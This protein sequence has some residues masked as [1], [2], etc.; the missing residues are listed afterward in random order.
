MGAGPAQTEARR[1]RAAP[2]WAWEFY[3][4]VFLRR[5]AALATEEGGS[6]EALAA[7]A[8]ADMVN[9]AFDDG[10]ERLRLT[11]PE[12][13]AS[14]EAQMREIDEGTAILIP[15]EEVMAELRAKIAKAS[16]RKP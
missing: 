7:E 3:R 11:E 15:H 10:P 13:R 1:S 6:P 12:L 2:E 14:L 4:P 5:L 16:A 8:V 9:L